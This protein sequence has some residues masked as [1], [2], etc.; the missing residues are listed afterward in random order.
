MCPYG[1]ASQGSMTSWRSVS[2][3]VR[4]CPSEEHHQR[5]PMTEWRNSSQVKNKNLKCSNSKQLKRRWSWH[6][7]WSNEI[8]SSQ[9]QG[10]DLRDAV[11]CPWIQHVRCVCVCND[12]IH[13]SCLTLMRRSPIAEEKFRRPI[14]VVCQVDLNQISRVWLKLVCSPAALCSVQWGGG[15]TTWLLHSCPPTQGRGGG[16]H[17]PP[18]HIYAKFLQFDARE[19]LERTPENQVGVPGCFPAYYLV[20]FPEENDFTVIAR[21]LL[22][23]P[24]DGDCPACLLQTLGGLWDSTGEWGEPLNNCTNTGWSPVWCAWL[25][26]SVCWAMLC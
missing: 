17:G 14:S 22:W 19:S 11:P 20:L 1:R 18:D 12:E 7:L 26:R 15:S 10:W 2:G 23:I 6:Q 9:Q 21:Y 25:K 13:R 24:K 4:S 16:L 5:A 3:C 8:C